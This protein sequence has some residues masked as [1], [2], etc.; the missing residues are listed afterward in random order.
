MKISVISFTK[1]GK[2]T[3][4]KIENALNY[5]EQISTYFHPEGGVMKW[6]KEQFALNDALIFVGAC[7]IAVRAIAPHI[8]DKLTDSAVIVIDEKGKFV[9]PVLSGHVGGAN[10]LA[11]HL[12]QILDAEPVITTATDVNHKFAVDVFARQNR[13]DIFN[14]NG[15]VKVSSKILR[16]EKIKISIEKG[17]SQGTVPEEV[18]IIS[19]PPEEKADVVISGEA[20]ILKSAVLGLKPR[21]YVLGVGCK[22]GKDKEELEHFIENM[23]LKKNLNWN[24]IAVIAS[25]DKKKNEK[26]IIELSYCKGIPYITF[27]AEELLNIKGDFQSSDFVRQTVGVDNVCERAAIA[28]CE[29]NGD[30]IVKKQIENGK[31]LAIAKRQITINWKER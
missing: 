10:E 13:F 7:G 28:A 25:I 5:K 4:E 12:S 3:A 21:E 26:G 31:T 29:G 9:I 6:T 19:Y 20:E 15:I 16:G 17:K 27:S 14:K 2:N 22:E 8:K 18:E 23:L 30:L 11:L 1:Q 24:D